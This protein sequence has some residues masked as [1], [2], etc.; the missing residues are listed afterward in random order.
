M[1][2]DQL[3]NL[4]RQRRTVRYASTTDIS[5]DHI[6][7]ILE[8]AKLAPSF[9]KLYPYKIYA[10]TNSQEGK[11][12]KESLLEYFRCGADRPFTTWRGKEML[13]P[14]LSGLV[15]AY[16]WKWSTSRTPDPLE[17]SKYGYGIQDATISATMAMMA[18]E[19]LGLKTS[20][21][22]SPKMRDDARKVLTDDDKENLLILVTVS[23]ENLDKSSSPF[24]LLQMI[25]YKGQTARILLKKHRSIVA[26]PGIT[27]I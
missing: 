3:M 14:V 26:Q 10:L 16:T 23:N 2:Y 9:D 7:K 27:L 21:L 13:Q 25:K 11:A 17:N 24:N 15:L 19:S 5:N 6:D 4:F 22:I 20:F 8:A 18:A 12:K 1:L